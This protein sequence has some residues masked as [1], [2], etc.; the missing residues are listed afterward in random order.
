MLQVSEHEGEVAGAGPGEDEGEVRGRPVGDGDLGSGQSPVA[1]LHGHAFRPDDAARL[2]E[3]EGPDPVSARKAGEVAAFLLVAP[4]DQDRLRHR[5]GGDEGDRGE[6]PAELFG[7]QHEL[8]M[9]EA[10]AA[11]SFGDDR[12]EPAHFAGSVPELPAHGLLRFE[13]RTGELQG[14]A[15]VEVVAGG[16]PQELLLLGEVEVHRDRAGPGAPMPAGQAAGRVACIKGRSTNPSSQPARRGRVSR[17]PS[18][19]DRKSR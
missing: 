15:V 16:G 8:R 17:H 12:A 11:P 10:A 19:S 1:M 6:G 5:R 7:D 3:G 14:G 4:G 2:G 9:A 13:D 18:S